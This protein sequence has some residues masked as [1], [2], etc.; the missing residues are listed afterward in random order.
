[1]TPHRIDHAEGVK[2]RVPLEPVHDYYPAV[3]D[4]DTYSTVQAM[5][6]DTR[7]PLR[8][9]HATSKVANV[10]GGLAKCPLCGGAMTL[11]TKGGTWRYLVC[12]A[13]KSGAGCRYRAVRYT[14]VERRL[15]ECAGEIAAGAP[16]GNPEEERLAAQLESLDNDISNLHDRLE[17]LLETAGH[18]PSAA[19]AERIA[20]TEAEMAAARAEERALEPKRAALVPTRWA[21]RL[22]DVVQAAG[23]DPLDRQILNAALRVVLSSVVVNYRTGDLGFTWKHGGWSRLT[24]AWPDEETTETAD[25]VP[26]P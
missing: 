11:V 22:G 3:V 12:T 13:A 24:Y 10:L 6:V 14:D 21:A 23:A 2:R 5:R 15:I 26:A 25:A 7:Q 19:L 20:E 8:G 16:T 1:M 18:R 17:G 4:P 9:R